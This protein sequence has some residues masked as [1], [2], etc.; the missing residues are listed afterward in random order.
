MEEVSNCWDGCSIGVRY[1]DRDTTFVSGT[2]TLR[3]MVDLA[4]GVYTPLG[5]DWPLYLDFVM[6]GVLELLDWKVGF[7]DC[8]LRWVDGKGLVTETWLRV[9]VL[10]PTVAG[11]FRS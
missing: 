8:F 10:F 2:L 1:R 4:I 3:R 7:C 9:R 6:E 11:M 5:G